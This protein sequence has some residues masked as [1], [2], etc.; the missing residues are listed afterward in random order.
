MKWDRIKYQP[1]VPLGADGKLLTG[2]KEHI[3]LSRKAATEGMVLLKNEN[4]TL[5][6]KKGERIAIFGIG[7]LDYIKG[8]GGSGEVYSKY[9]RNIYEG[10]KIKESENKLFVFDDL[11]KF[12]IKEYEAQKVNNPLAL[13][14]FSQ[15]NSE[16]IIQEPIVPKDL[17]NRAK[18]Y[19][20]TAIICIRR[21]SG[22][23]WDRK[24]EKGD[25]YLSEDEAKLVETVKQN[26]KRIIAILDVGGIIDSVWFKEEEKIGAALLA[27][28]AGMEGGLAI[29]DIIC[30][31]VNPSG[32]LVDT[33]AKKFEYYPS[34]EH[35]NDSE[36]YVDYNEDIY[37]GYRY[38]ET[39]PDAQKRVC[40]PFGFGLS[41]TVFDIHSI[42]AN[43]NDEF[44]TVN[45]KV[46][47]IGKMAGKEVIQ[48]YFS[49]P[50]GKL[51]KPSKQLIGFKKTKLLEVG[52]TEF[53]TI[54]LKIDDMA[55]FDDTG[56]VQMSAYVL[57][58]GEYKI[59][60]GNS[61][62][63]CV[64]TELAF[65][66]KSNKT[67][68][69]LVQRCAPY[70]IKRRMKQDGEYDYLPSYDRREALVIAKE[71]TAV[72][73]PEKKNLYAVVTGEITLDEFMAQ[74]KVE[75]LI[76]LCSGQRGMG[77]ANTGSFG[78]LDSYGIPYMGTIDGPAGVRT[79]KGDN[80]VNTV[81]TTCWPCATLMACTWDED[82]IFTVARAGGM[83]VKENNVAVWLTPA[84]NIHRSPLCGRNF[85]YFSEDPFLTGKA[86]AA[87]IK[88]IQSVRIAATP[89]HFCCNNKEVNRND[90]DSR[91]SERAL[92]EIYLKGFEIAVKEADP[93]VIMTSYNLLNGE[94]TSESYELITGILRGEWGYKG[95]VTTDWCNNS[96][97]YKELKAG[98][99]IK[100]PF[101]EQ[102]EVLKAYKEG[103]ISKAE[104]E[105][106]AKRVV[107][108]AL[109]LD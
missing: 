90:S 7:Q 106:C 19:T 82:L 38:F 85:E 41:F 57:E 5:P 32:K 46:T 20:D 78:G 95:V 93:W 22:E 40:Y 53:I 69:Q 92:R 68:K 28:Q 94:E 34:S 60:V 25:F 62:R 108:L 30:G 45:C 88:G 42:T 21:F 109:K 13:K 79:Y 72:A 16:L 15:S 51:G 65:K 80:P 70:N 39:I 12:Y 1:C 29:A 100:M 64:E 87:V 37:V 44:I 97:H 96:K 89:K 36:D 3:E 91:V 9:T 77:I 81:Y 48:V 99:D 105:A 33:F 4:E 6:I 101:G 24:S 66:Q 71:N 56:K 47:N 74:L 107:E 49:A 76:E 54:K 14:G 102:K 17:I 35:F 63:N 55:S 67:V 31:D 10:L 59:F 104:I 86:A 23:G 83:E 11:A 50:K 73:P 52:E 27:W 18:L 61:V 58:K 98:N 75:E 2:S 43:A 103:K 84:M 8:G 26:F